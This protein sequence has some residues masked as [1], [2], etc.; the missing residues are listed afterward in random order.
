MHRLNF[1]KL[2]QQGPKAQL[3]ALKYARNFTSFA[4][5]CSKEIQKL[6]GSL[7]YLGIGLENSPYSSYLGSELW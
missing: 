1:I 7:I 3:E 5:E 2:V 4:N 6:M